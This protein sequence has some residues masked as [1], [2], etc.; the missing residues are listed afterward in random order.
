LHPDPKPSKCILNSLLESK[1]QEDHAVLQQQFHRRLM[2]HHESE[3]QLKQLSFQ[4]LQNRRSLNFM[5]VDRAEGLYKDLKER[6]GKLSQCDMP[7]VQRVLE[8]LR[9]GNEEESGLTNQD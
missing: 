2:Q 5:K 3:S 4:E 6:T 1:E 9:S 7:S 8:E